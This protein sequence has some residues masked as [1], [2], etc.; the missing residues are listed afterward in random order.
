MSKC[1]SGYMWYTKGAGTASGS[2]KRKQK[3]ARFYSKVT[4]CRVQRRLLCS[5]IAADPCWAVGVP[6]RGRCGIHGT[7]EILVSLIYGMNAD[8]PLRQSKLHVGN[9]KNRLEALA[10]ADD[11]LTLMSW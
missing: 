10:V 4:Y 9:A 8:S 3:Q 11:M 1:S 7:I 6:A 2:K 5:H